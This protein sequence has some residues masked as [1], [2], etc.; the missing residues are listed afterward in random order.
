M[1]PF[2][3]KKLK[4]FLRRGRFAIKS[5]CSL[6]MSDLLEKKKNFSFDQISQEPGN[7]PKNKK[8]ILFS[9]S[10]SKPD[11]FFRRGLRNLFNLEIKSHTRNFVQNEIILK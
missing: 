11:I 6:K 8:K 9:L 4:N 5:G 3:I 1:N 2:E 7:T 10:L